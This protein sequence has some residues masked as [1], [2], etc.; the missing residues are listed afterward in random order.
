L[1]PFGHTH[2]RT[3]DC[4]V[5]GNYKS[6]ATHPNPPASREK[7]H[8]Q[9]PTGTRR[10]CRGRPWARR[11]TSKCGERHAPSASAQSRKRKKLHLRQRHV[12]GTAATGM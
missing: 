9:W 4:S 8:E 6:H 2:L 12:A 1:L 7:P 11:G 10:R 5:N 3:G